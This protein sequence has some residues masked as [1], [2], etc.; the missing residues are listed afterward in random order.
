MMNRKMKQLALAVGV[1]LG[2]M[3]LVPSAQ[4]VN[5][6]ANNQGQ[7]LIFP[8]YTVNSGW[9]TL[10]G[11]TNTSG[12]VVAA[13]VR[14]HEAYNSRDVFDFVIILSPQ[15]VWTGWVTQ[16][17]SGTP[18]IFTEDRSCTVGAISSAG[19]PFPGPVSY[20]GAAADGGPT[21]PNRAN[22]GYVEVTMMGAVRLPAAA[23]PDPFALARGAVHAANGTPPG[24]AALVAA[25]QSPT[26]LITL[27]GQFGYDSYAGTQ[28]AVNAAPGVGVINALNP[29]AGSFSL[30]N[31]ITGLSSSGR[32]VTLANFWAPV[33]PGGTGNGGVAAGPWNN[34]ITAQLPPASIPAATVGL[35]GT[36]YQNSWHEPSLNSANTNG[37]AVAP[38]SPLTVASV[39]V[40]GILISTVSGAN[41]NQ[42]GNLING[43]GTGTGAN[44]VSF[45]LNATN[46]I[47]E[48]TRR[49][50]PAAGWTTATDWVVTFP[51]KTFYTDNDYG[52]EFA[53]RSSGRVLVPAAGASLLP[54][55][56][57]NTVPAPFAE[58]FTNRG[59]P[60]DAVNLAASPANAVLRGSSCVTTANTLYNR[61][62]ASVVGQGFSPGGTNT[63]CYE[64]NVL[65]F[66]GSNLLGAASPIS[67]S[68]DSLPGIY[69]WLNLGLT[70]SVVAGQTTTTGLPA[71]GFQI[72]T[73]TNSVTG[74]TSLNSA[75]IVDHS[76]LP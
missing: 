23:T 59:A 30:V 63:L 6:A 12:S 60:A 39:P 17:A 15:D 27:Q 58:Y 47:N 34:L 26:S 11:I 25:F 7:V 5:V 37:Y 9:S 19:Q 22:Q 36:P 3:A 8:Y 18:S 68:L 54:V 56:A 46:V 32:P 52:N 31:G 71:I 73:R 40:S 62:E 51:T 42:T 14:F 49:T 13:K 43:A 33:V 65:T 48:W 4:A 70:A 2:S 21:T 50:D 28:A 74:N 53:G 72:T 24:C 20:T 45:V 55:L 1:A 29:L 35:V 10:F 16:N 69:G 76:Y 57:S 66:A 67:Q 75:S 41:Q 61:E 44:A 38:E 64:S